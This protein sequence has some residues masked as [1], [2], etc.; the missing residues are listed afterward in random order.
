MWDVRIYFQTRTGPV[1]VK[2][3]WIIFL[4]QLIMM[5]QEW[6]KS[7]ILNRLPSRVQLGTTLFKLKIAA[8]HICSA[9]ETK[10]CGGMEPLRFRCWLLY[11][12]QATAKKHWW[13]H[14]HPAKQSRA[15]VKGS[16]QSVGMVGKLLHPPLQV[17]LFCNCTA[18]PSLQCL[19]Y[20]NIS[21]C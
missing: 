3:S 20:V 19:Q 15:L 2:C 1:A 6:Y 12:F 4:Q 8:Q 14:F 9:P 16:Y 7:V 18:A 17:L 21:R 5:K 13:P 11:Q 10:P